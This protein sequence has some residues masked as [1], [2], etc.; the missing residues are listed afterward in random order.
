VG[1][2]LDDL[3]EIFSSRRD[4]W[5][6]ESG[7]EVGANP[8]FLP[9]VTAEEI[10]NALLTKGD[11]PSGRALPPLD[12]PADLVAAAIAGVDVRDMRGFASSGKPKTVADTEPEASD[13]AVFERVERRLFAER[14]WGSAALG[15]EAGNKRGVNAGESRLLRAYLGETAL[16]LY[17]DRFARLSRHYD[18]A[19]LEAVERVWVLRAIDERWQRHIVEMQVLRNSV[20]VRAFG[21]LDPMEEYRIDGARAFVDMVRDVRRKTLANV[22]FFVGSA[23]EPTL[24]FELEERETETA[25]AEAR[26]ARAARAFKKDVPGRVAIAE[27]LAE[28]AAREAVEVRGGASAS[29]AAFRETAARANEAA[30]AMA[31]EEQDALIEEERGPGPAAGSTRDADAEQGGEEV[32]R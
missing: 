3:R 32:G 30:R 14:A 21:Q 12:A 25:E 10:K 23:V 26:A 13:S 24:D 11:M 17:L 6:R 28:E 22:F 29:A 19:D 4:Q 31:L 7:R 27:V 16:A 18:R 8:H 9:G 20:N 15:P 1:D 5:L 2:A